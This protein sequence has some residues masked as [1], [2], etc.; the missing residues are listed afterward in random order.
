VRDLLSIYDFVAFPEVEIELSD[1]TNIL[2]QASISIKCPTVAKFRI[3]LEIRIL[4]LEI[5]VAV[6]AEIFC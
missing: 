4:C 5:K 2:A 1:Q 3:C 6:L